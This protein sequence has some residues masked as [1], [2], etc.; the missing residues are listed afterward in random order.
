MISQKKTLILFGDVVALTISFFITLFLSFPENLEYQISLHT[1]PFILLYSIWILIIYIFNLYDN[2]NIRPTVLTA[3][4]IILS[5]LVCG[6]VGISMFYLF[7]IFSISPKSNLFINLIIFGIL[8][9]II[10]RFSSEIIIG[11]FSERIGI[12][13]V[14]KESEELFKT[15]SEKNSLGYKAIIISESIDEILSLK[16]SVEKIIIAKNIDTDSLMKITKRGIQTTTL[17]TAYEQTYEK[18]PVNLMDDNVTVEILSKEKNIFYKILSKILSISLGLFIILITL[19]VT[20][21]SSIIIKIEDGR[22][23]L[24]KQMRVGKNHKNFLVWKFQSMKQNAEISGAV[25]AEEKDPRIT[26]FGKILR[27]LHIDEIPQMINI[28]K[29]DITLVGP[30]P[31]RPEFVEKLE[32][33]IPYYFLR[34]SIKPGFTGWAQIKYRYARSVDDSQS[35]FEYDLYYLKNRNI[36]LDIGIILK[37]VQ[38]I[39]TH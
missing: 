10:R 12:F 32:K 25:W 9:T 15:L 3:Q 13:G 36:F 23:I 11:Q 29:G 21:I 20:I 39:F 8:F 35:K 24:Y 30:R 1:Q 22:E 26:K 17:L 6:V 37:T 7:P 2:Q 16:P 5:L 19:P 31:E 28:I 27:K 4:K 34:H 33:E 14:K 18:I 38:I